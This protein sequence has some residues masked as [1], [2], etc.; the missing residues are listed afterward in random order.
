MP[1]HAHGTEVRETPLRAEPAARTVAKPKPGSP[2]VVIIGGGGTGAAIAWDLVLRG[3]SVI[4]LERGELT[5][6]TTGRHHGQMH[7]GARYAVGDRS[8]ARECMDETRILRRLVPDAIEYNGGLFVALNDADA[9]FAPTFIDACLEAGIPARETSLASALSMEPNLIPT[10]RRAVWVPDGT[11]DA[12]RLPLAFFASARSRG[13]DIRA[14]T[15]VVGIDVERGAVV[16]VLALDRVSGSE[17]RLPADL[18]VNATGAWSTKT[19]ALAGAAIEVTPAPG[20]MVAVEGRLCNMVV[21]H[22]HP[23]GDGDIIVPQ[24]NLSIIGSTQRSVDDPDDSAVRRDEVEALLSYAD[25]MLPGFSSR[26]VHAAWTAARPLAGRSGDEGRSIS[27]D[28]VAVDHESSGGPKGFVSAI[29][30]KATVL[31]AMAEKT[32]DLACTKLGLVSPCSTR[33]T[34]LSPYRDFFKGRD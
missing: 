26:P 28:F 11:L 1:V 2:R 4:L 17:C 24:R 5:S 19:C 21:S 29:G 27:R 22:L 32:A 23:A 31:R 33:E 34:P 10:I 12:F 25:A 16:S 9:D 15:E 3:C 30:G 18:V 20:T 7:C 6:G 14:F 13:A 8:I